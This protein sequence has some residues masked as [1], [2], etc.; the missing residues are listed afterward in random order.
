MQTAGGRHGKIACLP[1]DDRPVNYDYPRAS[2]RRGGVQNRT[3]TAGAWLG[4]PWRLSRHAN[5]WTGW[6]KPPSGRM[7]CWWRWIRS[8]RRIDPQPDFQRKL[9]ERLGPPIHLEAVEGQ[10]PHLTILAYNVIMRRRPGRLGRGGKTLLGR[11]RQSYIPFLRSGTQIRPG[12][13][14]M[15]NRLTG[16]TAGSK[17]LFLFTKTTAGRES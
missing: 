12:E 10:A 6:K 4:N 3:A 13:P 2:W 5:S 8:V 11:I 9:P 17:F 15:R 7:H 1:L 16:A 14:A